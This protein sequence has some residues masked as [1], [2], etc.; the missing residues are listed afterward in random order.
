MKPEDIMNSVNDIE[1]DMLSDVQKIRTKKKNRKP[2]IKFV[3]VAAC[4]C[5]VV[6]AVLGHF[7]FNPIEPVNPSAQPSTHLHSNAPVMN[8]FSVS[9]A[10]YPAMLKYP[11]EDAFRSDNGEVDWVAYTNAVT[12]WHEDFKTRNKNVASSGDYSSFV[13]S[14]TKVFLSDTKGENI[15][16]SPVNVYMAMSMLAE[17]TGGKTRHQI[18][19][20]LGADSIEDL[21]VK[22][23]RLWL[24]NYSDDG[25][26]TNILANSVWM[27]D[28]L[29]YNKDTLDIL[30][31][32]YYASSFS[33]TMGSSEYNSALHNWLNEQTG[34]LLKK[35]AEG[36]EFTSD[37]VLSLAST[38]YFKGGWESEFPE[39]LTKPDIFNSV[40]GKTS[41]DFMYQML[42]G[43]PLYS[44]DDYSA[45]T[46]SFKNGG[47]MWFILPD[48]GTSPEALIQSGSIN[49][50]LN[51]STPK[52]THNGHLIHF[53]MP[54][55]DIVS[56][57]EL[58]DYTRQLGVTDVFDENKA[59]FSPILAD[60][61]AAYVSSINHSARVTV[62]EKGC[63]AAAFTV[64]TAEGTMM[65]DGKEIEFRLNR[66]FIFVITSDD[67]T[68][69]FVGVVNNVQPTS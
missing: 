43:T 39:H 16:Y 26:K 17:S 31:E 5:I 15:V 23:N 4:L 58:S 61:M 28:N 12:K 30:A 41:I 3:A 55:F 24:S 14:T 62:D 1:D 69:L 50:I 51:G 44:D 2:W 38:V 37:M 59:D 67:S 65:P 6:G 19:T 56:S 21:R 32:K 8:P 46:L 25:V 20:L 48:E 45:T 60:N 42:N 29:S 64:I 57:S 47:K 10:V 18:L 11:S 63:T 54:K 7:H 36:L 9:N 68:P 13:N 27:N 53:Y 34:G 52:N 22:A 66:P 40:N 33:G 49:P 35:Q